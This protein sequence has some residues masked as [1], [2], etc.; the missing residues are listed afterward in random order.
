LFLLFFIGFGMKAGFV[1]LHTWLP[2]AHPAAP[3]HVSGTMSGVMIKMGIYGILRVLTYVQDDLF[4]I[5]I[6]ILAISA[7][8]GLLGVMLA[9]I[10]HDLKKLLAYH[11]I[12]NIGII[13]MGLGLGT[14]GLSL[15]NDILVILGFSGTLLH[16]LNHSLFKSLLFFSTGS[17][18]KNYHTL[19]IEQLGGVI[20]RMPKTALFFLIGSAAICGL[21]PLNGF[22][23][24]ML[25]YVGL[26][27]G[28]IAGTFYHSIVM[29]LAI[30]CLA[31]IGGLAIFCFTKVFGIVFLGS[32]RKKPE[33]EI[34]EVDN[35]MLFPQLLITFAILLIGL[36]PI[37]FIQ[38]ISLVVS[39][40]FHIQVDNIIFTFSD[41]FRQISIICMILIGVTGLL[42]FLRSVL[43]KKRNVGYSPT[44]G[45]GYANTSA[46]QQ[47]TS[48]SFA[49][50]FYK[51][52][53]P[54][55]ITETDYFSIHE[56]EIIPQKHSFK[57]HSVDVFKKITIKIID[58][59]AI[60]LKNLARLQTGLIQ[61]Y[62]L[63]AFIFILF[64][65][66]LLFLSLL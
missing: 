41:T 30:V 47:Y 64:I 44:W 39:D 29:L 61:H 27:N 55:L 15:Q 23:S 38:P 52:A 46:K 33:H 28:L 54:V 62:I 40:I 53:H 65:F 50:S 4:L 25:I 37:L 5:G 11:S 12:E 26:F 43:L 32:E 6:I 24:E 59:I 21:P 17:V 7:I 51:I 56:E 2:D 60:I 45:C 9:I 20:H 66:A 36:F 16:V 22:I 57:S 48:T 49:N 35:N 63:Y 34:S 18:Y 1:P 58:F 8:S 13:G 3:S 19:N 31:S 42:F 10:Q 14:I